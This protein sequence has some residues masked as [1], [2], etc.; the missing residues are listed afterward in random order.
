MGR[1]EQRTCSGMNPTDLDL[2]HCSLGC[3]EHIA[4]PFRAPSLPRQC[5][6][7][8]LSDSQIRAALSALLASAKEGLELGVT[9]W[10]RQVADYATLVGFFLSMKEG[11]PIA[12]KI[13]APRSYDCAADTQLEAQLVAK[14][15]P[16]P[17]FPPPTTLLY[18]K[19]GLRVTWLL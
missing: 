6:G 1:G 4:S 11:T 16:Q 2:F 10:T 19:V 15:P 12:G 9:R 17:P 7:A 14:I 8:T 18:M 3:Q 5:V 13:K